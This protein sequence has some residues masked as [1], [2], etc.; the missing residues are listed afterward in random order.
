LCNAASASAAAA[1][2]KDARL[3]LHANHCAVPIAFETIFQRATAAQALSY[4]QQS[5]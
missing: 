3:A 5:V 4:P 1:F 2:E